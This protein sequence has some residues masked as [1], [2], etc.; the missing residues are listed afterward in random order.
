MR[1]S[2]SKRKLREFGIL[3]GIGFPALIGYLI[4]LISGHKYIEWTIL[5]GI[6]TLTLVICDPNLLFYPYKAWM[7]LGLILGKINSYVILGL[8]FILILQPI[9]FIMKFLN[10]DPLRMKRKKNES[11]YRET[12]KNHRVD[13]TKIF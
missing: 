5:I 3:F 9:A 10:Y 12:I 4:P 8:I 6:M 7:K 1:E 11:S 13:L 2:I